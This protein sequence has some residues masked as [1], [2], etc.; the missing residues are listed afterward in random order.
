VGERR[1]VEVGVATLVRGDEFVSDGLD[2]QHQAKYRCM[3]G[4]SHPSQARPGVQ[5]FPDQLYVV[6]MLENPLRWRS[7]YWNYWMFERECEV[8]G[9]ILYTAEVAFGE[10]A[11]EVTQGG[12]P[13]HLQLRT[14]SE[15]W[16]KENALNLL[17]QR[18]P[19]DAKYVAWIDA[20]IRFSRPDWAQETLQLLQHYDVLQM[21]S[22]AQD[23]GPNYEP[24]TTTPGFL[25]KWVTDRPSPHD[26][27]FMQQKKAYGYYGVKS[28]QFWHPGFAWAA[29]RNALEKTKQ[30]GIL[31]DLAGQEY[32]EDASSCFL[33]SGECVFDLKAVGDA[34]ANASAP[35]LSQ[36]NGRLLIWLPPQSGKDYIIGVDTAGGGSEGDYAC[37]EVVERASG[38]Q[39]AELR[40]H[41]PPLELARRVAELGLRYQRALLAIER[42]N[43]GY[44]VLAHLQNMKYERIFEKNEQLGW[45]TS[46]ATRPAMIENMASLLVAEPR[47]FQSRRL[48]EE[49]RTFV[50]RPE[51]NAAAAEGTHDDCVM[52]MAIALAV[53]REHAGPR[54]RRRGFEMTSLT[55]EG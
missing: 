46:A 34:A 13:R 50:R 16:H 1:T 2:T 40:G 8:A 52:A 7:R 37:A 43:H 41:F 54:P 10:R 39:C 12:S 4:I 26:S 48:L 32:A 49:C 3:P 38:L 51:G 35:L 9:A 53:R 15:I 18:L 55:M 33:A 20:D 36:D 27:Q 24:L 47:L 21:F 23:V 6:T 45:L 29:K 14:T 5:A 30:W 17:I 25:Y 19:S 42:N 28:G 31:R 11:F 22:H 44:G